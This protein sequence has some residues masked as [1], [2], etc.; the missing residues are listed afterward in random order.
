MAD[1]LETAEFIQYY[2]IALDLEEKESFRQYAMAGGDPKEFKWSESWH[3]PSPEEI[4]KKLI[5][6]AKDVKM[7]GIRTD[8]ADIA[9]IQ[10]RLSADWAMVKVFQR[11]DGSFIDEQGNPVQPPPGYTFIKSEKLTKEAMLNSLV[12]E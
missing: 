5:E 6:F 11:E 2:A 9:D 10:G 8:I 1:G 12:G 4:G 7:R 3:E